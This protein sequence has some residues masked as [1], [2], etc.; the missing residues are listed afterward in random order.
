MPQYN[1]R[2]VDIPNDLYSH[3]RFSKFLYTIV[4]LIMANIVLALE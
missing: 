3:N 2:D 4:R 1:I